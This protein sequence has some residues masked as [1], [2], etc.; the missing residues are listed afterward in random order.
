MKKPNYLLPYPGQVLFTRYAC[1][2][3][4]GLFNLGKKDEKNCLLFLLTLNLS[5]MK[6]LL[7]PTRAR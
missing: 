3:G 2:R 7:R 5:F 1:H 4:A 6:K